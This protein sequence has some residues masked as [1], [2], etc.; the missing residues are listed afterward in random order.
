MKKIMTGIAA[1]LL[2]ACFGATVS[3]DPRRG[4]GRGPWHREWPPE[5]KAQWVEFM[6]ERNQLRAEF[7][8]GEVAAGRMS[9]KA[10]DAH[11]ALMDEHLSKIKDAKADRRPPSAEERE[12]ARAARR[13]YFGKVRELEIGSIRKAIAAGSI[14][15]ERGEKMIGRLEDHEERGHG[16]YGGHGGCHG[17]RGGYGSGGWHRGY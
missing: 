12:A 7:L 11:I 17:R 10:A 4:E 9:R 3:A 2:I 13:D 15:K 16:D 5:Q 1:A 8:D 14:D 6:A